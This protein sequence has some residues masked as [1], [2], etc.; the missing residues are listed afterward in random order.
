L[1]RIGVWADWNGDGDVV[2]ANES[3]TLSDSS[4]IDGLNTITATLRPPAGTS[5]GTQFL[6]VRVVEGTVAPAFSGVSALKGE[7]EDY[8]VSITTP[9]MDYGDLPDTIIGTTAGN[10]QTL[11]ND[12]GP[13]HTANSS[14]RLGAAV[15]A[16]GN[17]QP[18]ST[19]T[20]DGTDDDGVP[21]LPV[22]TQGQSGTLTI[23]ATNT[24]GST[25]FLKAWI[26]WN[27]DGNL[28]AAEELG[29]QI[30]V[31]NNTSNG[32][33]SFNFAVPGTAVTGVQLGLRIRLASATIPASTGPVGTGE[34][35][36]YLITVNVSTADFGDQPNFAAA[37]RTASTQIRVGTNATDTDTSYP[38]SG[39][40]NAD[41][42]SGTDDEDLTMPVLTAGTNG[43]L[44]ISV[45]LT[46]PVTS[47]RIGVWADW[48]GDNDVSD[49]NETVTLS[50]AS[51]VTGTNTITATLSP[52]LGITAGA[53]YLRVIAQEGTTAPAFS[54]NSALKG[55]V[56]DYAITVNTTTLDFGD[57]PDTG[58]GTGTGNYQTLNSDGNPSHTATPTTLRLGATVDTEA[59]GQPNATA[60]GDGVDEDGISSMPVFE[61]GKSFTI[62]VAVLNNTGGAARIFGFIDFNNDGDFADTSETLTAVV[63]NSSATQQSVNITGTTPGTAVIGTFGARFRLATATTLT[64]TGT[65]ANG[66]VEDYL[67]TAACPAV[68]ITPTSLPAT[69]QYATYN[70]TLT[71]TGG[72][73]PYS[74]TV[75]SGA[76][77]GG[78]TM[79]SAGVFSGSVI[80]ASGAYV[81]SV[82][83]T[84]VNGCSNTQ[85]YTIS[86]GSGGMSVG[87]LVFLDENNNGLK[88]ANERGIPNVPVEVWSAGVDG[89]VNSADDQ[90]VTAG[91]A[92]T[93]NTGGMMALGTFGTIASGFT[94]LT[95][96]SIGMARSSSPN[97]RQGCSISKSHRQTRRSS[98]A[99]SALVRRPTVSISTSRWP[100]RWL[101]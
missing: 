57:L 33:F 80:S 40:A 41:D 55:E 75:I 27:N 12:N 82:R 89:R 49:T 98:P 32:A 6:R 15:D 39:A 50:T 101:F 90:P 16:E 14:L 62:P 38:S 54:G 44:S 78:M 52:P 86:V 72:T 76:I 35:E 24:F 28:T 94:T 51:L 56:E 3:V 25:G 70:Q 36:D 97:C 42:T 66:E 21:S 46:S 71:A 45:A 10:Y 69:T 22:L 26:D 61:R 73:A 31:P 77:P 23:N 81:F 47:G 29:T 79:S 68:T 34:V 9:T 95:A 85:N 37:S 58:T 43:T 4:L 19:A 53:K 5:I 100:V 84:D 92:S 65:T 88:D 13:S 64:S 11:S 17:G 67:V 7:V 59:D 18:N 48:N 8:P 74:W 91:T 20:G 60:N 96:R 2:D 1:G 99:S 93:L 30:S 83:S 87:N 63:V